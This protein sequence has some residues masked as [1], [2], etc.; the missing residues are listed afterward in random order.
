MWTSPNAEESGRVDSTGAF[1]LRDVSA[2]VWNV[3]L[4]G[5]PGGYY[6]QSIRAGQ[7]DVLRQGFDTSGSAMRLEIVVAPNAPSLNGV[8]R[9]S[10]EE[11]VAGATVVLAPQEPERRDRMQ[12]YRTA[13]T[14]QRGSFVLKDIAPGEYKVFAWE[15]IEA[16]AY[17]DPE[18]RKPVEGKGER[19]NLKEGDSQTVAIR[20]ISTDQ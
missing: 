13:T 9:D 6:V 2:D 4:T 20:V 3:S 11:A 5:L 8:V 14:D 17:M 15:D 18:F 1:Q 10:K 19:I 16:G 7:T 12:G